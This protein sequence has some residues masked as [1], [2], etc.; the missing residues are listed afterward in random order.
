MLKSGEN[1][2]PRVI[3]TRH[4][5]R[6]ALRALVE[7]R[8]FSTLSVKDVTERAGINRSTFYL[9]YAGLHEL[10]EDYTRVLFD[11]LRENIYEGDLSDMSW[12]SED[13][14]PYVELVFNH[15]KKYRAFY[16]SM[17]GKRGD[18]YFNRLFQ[19]LLS[20]LLFEPI[21]SVFS[22]RSTDLHSTLILKFYCNGF[23][24]IA[25]WWLDNDM[26]IA[27]PQASQQISR[28]ILPGYMQLMQA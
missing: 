21:A 26:P 25:S 19:D 13:V 3:R 12:G 20:E 15:L 11:E 7:E 27:I 8:S 22:Q 2:D 5:L 17:L 14:E 10:L 18:P 1:E 6:E 24:G 9:H 4:L 16:K 23:T 28:D